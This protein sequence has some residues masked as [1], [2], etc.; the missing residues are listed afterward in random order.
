MNKDS[1]LDELSKYLFISIRATSRINIDPKFKVIQGH[2]KVRVKEN[3]EKSEKMARSLP[4]I[5]EIS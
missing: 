1:D 5:I 3:V 4:I 2:F